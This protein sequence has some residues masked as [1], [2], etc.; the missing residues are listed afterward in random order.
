ML[1]KLVSNRLVTYLVRLL[2][3]HG[4]N[5]EPNHAVSIFFAQVFGKLES[6]PHFF[7][8]YLIREPHKKK[9][10]IV[11]M[12]SEVPVETIPYMVI[13]NLKGC[14]HCLFFM[15]SFASCERGSDHS[16]L[17]SSSASKKSCICRS[18]SSIILRSC[19]S[20]W[21]LR[22]PKRMGLVLGIIAL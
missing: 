9:A 21:G 7:A 10:W 20:L 1:P 22:L 4:V 19:A 15:A 13:L 2:L 16:T 3:N 8:V 5:V 14:Y 18:C 12:R 17:N 11:W 6:A